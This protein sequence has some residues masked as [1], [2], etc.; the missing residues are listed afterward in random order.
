VLEQFRIVIAT[1]GRLPDDD[2]DALAPAQR[3]TVMSAF[4][5]WAATR[6]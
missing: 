1:S 6:Q 5:D 2:V 3:D 4:R